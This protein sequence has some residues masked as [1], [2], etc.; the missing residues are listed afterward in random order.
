MR[1][2]TIASGSSGNSIYIGSDNTHILVDAGISKKR[3]EEGLNA[4]GLG[5]SDISAILVTHEHSDHIQALGV[6]SRKYHIPIMATGLTIGEIKKTKSLGAIDVD[7]FH[8]VK[9]DIP[10]QIGDLTVCPFHISHDAADPVA[11]RVECGERSVAV[12]TDLGVYDDYIVENLSGVNGI[13][14]E[15][16][17]DVNMLLAGSYPYHLKRRILGNF[18][19][20]S[21]ESSGRLLDRILHDNM[22]HIFLG[23]LSKENNFEELAYTTVANEITASDS[24]YKANDFDICVAKRETF[25]PLYNV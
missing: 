9:P 14:I 21:N 6:I 3:I 13:V 15:A 12:A 5:L 22:K 16:N 4:Y 11:Y 20:L 10:L 7:V 23:H 19:H 17:H 8:A 2:G 25:S 18:G 1:F 24:V